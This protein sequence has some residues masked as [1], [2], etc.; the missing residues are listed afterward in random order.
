MAFYKKNEREIETSSREPLFFYLVLPIDRS[1]Y[2]SELADSAQVLTDAARVQAQGFAGSPVEVLFVNSG[3]RQVWEM[4]DK[5]LLYPSNFVRKGIHVLVNLGFL[6][7]DSPPVQELILQA[8]HKNSAWCGM[9]SSRE[10]YAIAFSCKSNLNMLSPLFKS[11]NFRLVL[12][13]LTACI[14]DDAGEIDSAWRIIRQYPYLKRG[15][16]CFENSPAMRQIENVHC[17]SWNY[18]L[19]YLNTAFKEILSDPRDRRVVE[20]DPVRMIEALRAQRDIS[21]VPWIFNTLINDIEVRTGAIKP[22]SFPP[23]IHISLTG[24]CQIECRFCGYSH[25]IARQDFVTPAQILRMDFLRHVHTLRLHSGHGEPGMNRYLPEI[26]RQ[27]AMKF[28]HLDLNFFTNA[29]ALD[30]EGLM[31]AVI[32]NVRF[33]NASI[34]AADRESW[35]KQ[36]KT[37]R[38]D[39]VCDNLREL[40]EKKRSCG[41]IWPLV[42][43]SMVL[44]RENLFDLPRMPALCRELGIDRFTAFP[45]YALGYDS[46]EKFGPEMTLEACRDRYDGI[47]AETVCEAGKHGISLEIPPPSAKVQTAFGMETGKLYD[48]AGIEFNQWPMGRFLRGLDFKSPPQEYCHFLWRYAAVGSTYDIGHSQH[49]T[50]YLYPCIGPLSGVDF[51]RRTAFR[52]PGEQGF[53]EL[54]RNPVLTHL[55]KAQHR[56]GICRVCDSCRGGNTR[57]PK[58]FSRLEKEVDLFKKKWSGT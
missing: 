51:S 9:K 47:Y 16:V 39:K 40:L 48:F 17:K 2:N 28:T 35:K 3:N 14:D 45:Y 52:F 58:N 13:H 54:W 27:A 24:I 31:D 43:G 50:H 1:V 11:V 4:S 53:M 32:G 42:F 57:D 44:N 10:T 8:G 46:R 49:E 33:I 18:S 21:K 22:V 26:I 36:C 12:A 38:F 19:R 30:R 23:E 34:N 6:L 55:R 29:L 5:K 20:N 7:S 25:E 56:P 15:K 41:S 37:D